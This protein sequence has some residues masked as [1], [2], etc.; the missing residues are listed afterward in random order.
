MQVRKEIFSRL[1]FLLNVGLHYLTLDRKAG[2]LSGGEA[3]RIRLASQL[4]SRL[5]GAMYVL[6]EPTIGLHQRDNDRLIKTLH[7]L[8]DLGN[9]ILVVEHDEDVI[10]SSDYLV[11]IG[12]GAGVHGGDI[13]ATGPMPK[14]LTNKKSLTVAY[15]NGDKKIE[16]P[17]KRRKLLNEKLTIVGATEN[18]LKNVKVDIPL[19]RFVCVTGVSGS[20]KSSLVN[21]VLYKSLSKTL[22]GSQATP[23]KHKEVKGVDWLDKII[24][25]DQSA[26]GRTPRSNPAT[27]TGAFNA[28]RDLFAATPEARMRGYRVGRFSFNVKG[29]RC[30]N[31]EGNG[32]IA[33]EMHFLPTVYVTCEVCKGTR[34]DHETLQVK[35]KGKNIADVLAMTIEEAEDFF[36]EIPSIHSKI[37]ICRE[38]GL[39]YLTLGQSAK[40][41]S[42]GE[43]QRIKLAKEL[44]RRDTGRTLYVLDEPTIGLHYEDVKKLLDVLDRLVQKG[45][46]VLVI[47]HNLDVIKMA[48]HVIDMGPEGGEGG[49]KVVAKG[50]PEQIAGSEKSSTGKYL[51]RILKK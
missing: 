31:C 9:T 1:E 12:P 41:L 11:D 36:K 4:G 51:K 28:I 33:I 25:I 37:K 19:R 16:V 3:Q 46:S 2:T 42:G 32:V 7:E 29:G 26:I 24:N 14:I 5:V 34:Y 17:A 20:G 50:T 48:D 38:V 27:Y 18:N 10:M 22:H 44:A 39:D 35:Y 49:G 23:G 43:A 13:V 47:E 21:E 45:N 30:E 15:L 40:T 6:D 8:R